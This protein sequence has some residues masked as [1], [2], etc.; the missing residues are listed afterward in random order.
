MKKKRAIRKTRLQ[1][2][3]FF[4]PHRKYDFRV[5]ISEEQERTVTNI[6]N[7]VVPIPGDEELPVRERRKDRL[8][9][10]FDMWRIDITVVKKSNMVQQSP[11]Y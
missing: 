3:D 10:T 2:V 5:T 6:T 1:N 7:T 8:S 4:C 11:N 9:Y